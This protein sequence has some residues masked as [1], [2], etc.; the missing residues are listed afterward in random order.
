MKEAPSSSATKSVRQLVESDAFESAIL[1]LIVLNGLMMGLETFPELSAE[2]EGWFTAIFWISQG[3]FVLEMVLRLVAFAP[4][5]GAFFRDF[6]NTFDFGIVAASLLPM[7]GPLALV[8]RLFRVL[9]V[10]RILSV[11]DELRAFLD[12]MRVSVGI[13]FQ[14]IIVLAVVFY[15]FSVGGFYLFQEV[16]AAHWGNLGRAFLSVSYLALAQDVPALVEPVTDAAPG[17]VLFFGLFYA[18]L[19]LIFVNTVAAVL[20]QHLRARSTV[21]Q[22]PDPR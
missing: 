17:S 13:L 21:L 22:Q 20:S 4:R 18:G 10:I 3:V 6:W 5:F 15:I 8:A 14:A 9:R 12:Q 2:Y 16:D 11:S 1:T 19:A 7:V